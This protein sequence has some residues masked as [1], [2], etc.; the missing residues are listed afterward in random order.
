MQ[1]IKE[2][3]LSVALRRDGIVLL[4]KKT[5]DRLWVGVSFYGALV[6]MDGC[7]HLEQVNSLV[8]PNPF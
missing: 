4:R 1:L 6:Y 8:W 7:T 5:L 2:T 3:P